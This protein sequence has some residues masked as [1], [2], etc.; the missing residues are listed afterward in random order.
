LLKEV[1]KSI[2]SD[3]LI[4]GEDWELVGEG[5]AFQKEQ[6]SVRLVKFLPGHSQFQNL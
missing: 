4:P 1:Q 5:Y 3:L 6:Q 2:L